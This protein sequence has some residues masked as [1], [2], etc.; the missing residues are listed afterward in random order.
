[1]V[2]FLNLFDKLFSIPSSV[3]TIICFLI[4][5]IPWIQKLVII[6]SA[7]L[8]SFI[9]LYINQL[10]K[11]HKLQKELDSVNIKHRALGKQFDSNRN[12]VMRYRLGFQNIFSMLAIAAQSTNATKINKLFENFLLIQKQINDGGKVNE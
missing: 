12:L 6:L 7:W 2:I 8:I 11:Y 3:I 4:P 1:M 5:D 10:L 9:A